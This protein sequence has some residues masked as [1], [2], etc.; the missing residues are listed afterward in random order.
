MAEPYNRAHPGHQRPIIYPLDCLVLGNVSSIVTDGDNPDRR[1]LHFWGYPRK[2]RKNTSVVSDNTELCYV[3][4]YE[5]TDS[6][7]HGAE[8]NPI[9][10]DLRLQYLGVRL[11]EIEKIMAYFYE[12]FELKSLTPDRLAF[13]TS[14]GKYRQVLKR[15]PVSDWYYLFPKGA[16]SIAQKVNR[17]NVWHNWQPS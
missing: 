6:S 11:M 10:E 8:D 17:D 9:W 16:E 13:T 3:S 2:V 4:Y 5:P 7:S 15:W 12:H 14:G 1:A